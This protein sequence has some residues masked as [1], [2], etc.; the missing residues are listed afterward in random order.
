MGTHDAYLNITS[1]HHI[2]R[3]A[4]PIN[5]NGPLAF[6]PAACLNTQGDHFRHLDDL[7]PYSL[8]SCAPGSGDDHYPSRQRQ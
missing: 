1:G 8:R 6:R 7:H 4:C 5:S 3:R 2:G